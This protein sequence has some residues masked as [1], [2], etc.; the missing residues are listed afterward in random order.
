M[1]FF[2]ARKY[3]VLLDS[4]LSGS[5]EERQRYMVQLQHRRGVLVGLLG[6]KRACT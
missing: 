3:R 4:F 5:K 6:G 1:N 2:Y